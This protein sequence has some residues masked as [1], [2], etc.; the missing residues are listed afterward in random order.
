[1]TVSQKRNIPVTNTNN[2]FSIDLNSDMG[3]GYGAYKM[4]DD[5]SLLNIVSSANI[6]CGFHGGDPEI[7]AATFSLAKDRGVIAGAHPGYPDLWGFGRRSMQF[8]LGEIERLIAY[9][10][11]A[12]QAVSTY[13]GHPVRYIKIHGAL[14]N[15]CITDADIATAVCRAIKAVDPTLVCLA[16]ALGQ[17]FRIAS[18]MGLTVRSEIFADRAYTPEGFLVPRK[19]PGAVIHD[20]QEAAAR[21]VRMVKSGGIE[22]QSGEILLTPIDSI[23][24]H[25]DTPAA[26]NIASSVRKALEVDGIQIKSF[27]TDK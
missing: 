8:S 21:V 20:A 4:G 17:Q 27:I 6:A 25:S 23:C 7:M 2:K 3:E 9:Q 13:V 15:L 26:V 1:M 19:L 16:V 22:L 24:V 10:I 12:A 14:G 18:D 5:D 11:G